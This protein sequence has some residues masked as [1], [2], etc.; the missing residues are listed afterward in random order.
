MVR[1]AR[2]GHSTRSFKACPQLRAQ[3]S[4]SSCTSPAENVAEG[5]GSRFGKT[6]VC[7]W[8]MCIR[9][10]RPNRS[11]VQDGRYIRCPKPDSLVIDLAHGKSCLLT[12]SR[13]MQG[14][15]G[16]ENGRLC[17][18]PSQRSRGRLRRLTPLRRNNDVDCYW[19]LPDLY[20]PPCWWKEAQNKAPGI[21]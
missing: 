2:Q 14:R 15:Q 8:S 17:K 6:L 20:L 11:W 21:T 4:L 3:L 5:T 18:T 16:G 7:K 12:Q 10:C 9:I 19:D 13:S 1:G